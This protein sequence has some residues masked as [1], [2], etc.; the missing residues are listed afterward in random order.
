MVAKTWSSASLKIW[1]MSR[2]D[3]ESTSLKTY[4]PAGKYCWPTPGI[5]I[6]WLNVTIVFLSA[7]CAIALSGSVRATRDAQN[8]SAT[9]LKRFTLF[10]WSN[11]TLS[12]GRFMR[13]RCFLIRFT[14]FLYNLWQFTCQFHTAHTSDQ[15]SS[16]RPSGQ[17]KNGRT[18]PIDPDRIQHLLERAFVALEIA[19]RCGENEEQQAVGAL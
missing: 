14:Q 12:W 7:R 5:S 16:P 13:L 10:I 1:T 9:T 6:L 4:L 11:L 2:L 18:L 8:I 3:S 15:K 17:D 19:I